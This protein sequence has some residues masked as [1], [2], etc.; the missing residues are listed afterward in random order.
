[1]ERLAYLD[2]RLA[3]IRR[4]VRKHA[5]AAAA[6][7]RGDANASGLADVLA[8]AAELRAELDALT[9]RDARLAELVAARTKA[10]AAA[11]AAASTLA[12][13]RKKAARRLEKQVGAA[14]AEL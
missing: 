12:Q 2:E 13:A 14:L 5:V 10:E 1:P 9:G 3:T 11:L 6:A 4:L 8:K 7:S